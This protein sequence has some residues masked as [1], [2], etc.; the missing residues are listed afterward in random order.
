MLRPEL[1]SSNEVPLCPDAFTG[2]LR[3]DALASVHNYEVHNIINY[4]HDLLTVVFHRCTKQ[5]QNCCTTW[6]QLLLLKLIYSR[7]VTEND[8]SICAM[9]TVATSE[10][11]YSSL[12]QEQSKQYDLTSF[13]LLLSGWHFLQKYNAVSTGTDV[14][15]LNKRLLHVLHLMHRRGINMRYV[16]ERISSCT[17]LTCW[18]NTDIWE[19]C[20]AI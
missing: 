13:T 9:Y 2:W 11:C 10:W 14:K 12:Y 6:F 18:F 19:K 3:A 15:S 8:I 5:P 7:C 20:G 4:S 17:M 16:S 1:V